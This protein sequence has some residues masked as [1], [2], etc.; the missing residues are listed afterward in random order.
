MPP[1]QR[2]DKRSNKP[3]KKANKR[4]PIYVDGRA[5]RP[6]YVDY[7]DLDLLTKLTN[8][9]GRIV[10]RRK[11]G[12]HAASQHAVAKA[13]AQSLKRLKIL[14]DPFALGF[15]RAVGATLSG[16]MRSAVRAPDGS[17]RCLPVLHY[18]L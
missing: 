14:S 3:M 5:P 13:R 8:R 16:K 11:T 7:K 12:C 15:Y 4:D 2:N 6:M 1:Y 18:E 17:E 10:S 9:H